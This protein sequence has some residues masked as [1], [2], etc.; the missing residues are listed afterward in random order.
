[1]WILKRE[2]QTL[3]HNS[4]MGRRLGESCW[5]CGIREPQAL[6]F[7]EMATKE[8]EDTQGAGPA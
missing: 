8:P 1:M 6:G 4:G 5:V 3:W 2:P 7:A